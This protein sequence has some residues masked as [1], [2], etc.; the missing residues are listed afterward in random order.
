MDYLFLL[1]NLREGILSW[2]T[3]VFFFF[4]EVGLVTSF[5][6]PFVIYWCIEKKAGAKILFCY[7]LASFI[8]NVVKVCACVKFTDYKDR[9][10]FKN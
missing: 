2:L 4:S 9:I 10:T 7:S 1:Q 3:P 8:T 6:V 5:L